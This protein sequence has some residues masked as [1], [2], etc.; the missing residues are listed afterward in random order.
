MKSIKMLVLVVTITFSSVLTASTEPK[1]AEASA[2]TTEVF[3]RLENPKFL[4]ETDV[5]V[6]VTLTLNKNNELV[7]LTVDSE[8]EGIVSYIKDRLNYNKV[9]VDIYNKGRNYI[10]PVRLAIKE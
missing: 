1:D 9:P 10:V 7:V 8:N 6:N 3:K 5:L 2:I 4:L